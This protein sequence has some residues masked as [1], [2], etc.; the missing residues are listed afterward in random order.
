MPLAQ[1]LPFWT[2]R[3]YFLLP[4]ANHAWFSFILPAF[5]HNLILFFFLV[6]FSGKVSLK[7]QESLNFIQWTTC[8]AKLPGNGISTSAG[9]W[10]LTQ[11]SH[12]SFSFLTTCITLHGGYPADSP[13][14]RVQV[15]EEK[16]PLQSIQHIQ[17]VSHS[18][19]HIHKAFW[20]KKNKSDN[21]YTNELK[22]KLVFSLVAKSLFHSYQM[23]LSK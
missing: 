17:P 19:R 21:L 3:F 2:M 16:H 1:R 8:Q 7:R 11:S 18:K 5:C 14:R 6:C 12:F 13:G 22:L 9:Q 23:W 20:K 15:H 10:A 4:K